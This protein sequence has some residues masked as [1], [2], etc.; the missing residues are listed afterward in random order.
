MGIAIFGHGY[1]WRD[2]YDGN[3]W[4]LITLQLTNLG[5]LHSFHPDRIAYIRDSVGSFREPQAQEY[6]LKSK[7]IS[8]FFS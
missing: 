5:T 8:V 1:R 3:R 6:I 4:L 2:I 7:A